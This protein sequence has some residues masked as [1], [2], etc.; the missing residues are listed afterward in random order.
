M[1]VSR[2]QLEELVRELPE[3][4]ITAAYEAV[5]RLIERDQTAAR[6]RL[7]QKL[8]D[9]GVLVHVATGMTPEEF[10]SFQPVPIRGKPLSDTVIEDRR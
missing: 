8:L 6:D 2:T 9:A 4:E 7:N 3:S 5:E 10:D 1:A